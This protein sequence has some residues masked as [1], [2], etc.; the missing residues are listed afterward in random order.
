MIKVWDYNQ[1]Y[2]ILRKKILRC[3]DDVFKSGTLVFGPALDKF[4]KNFTQFIGTKY[5]LGVG[6]GTDALEIAL[7]ACGVGPGDEV[8]TTSNTAV[9]TVTA[10]VNAGA[11]PCFVDVDEFYLMNSNLLENKINNKTK[12]IIPVHL[13]GQSCNMKNINKIAKKNNLYVIEDCAQSHGATYNNKTTGSLGDIGCFSFY[14][15]KILG[16]YGD[17]GFIT[18]NNQKLFDKMMRIRFLGMERKKMSSGHWNGKYYAVEHGTN[19]RLDEVHAA[20]LSVKL[21]YLKSWIK[22]RRNIA[23]KYYKSLNNIGL[24]LP[25]EVKGNE[26]A[27]Y[28]Y[29]VAHEKRDLIIKEFLKNDIHLNISYP[30]PIHIMEPYKDNVC[31]SCYCLENTNAFSKTIFSLPMHPYLQT[32]EQNKVIKVMKKVLSDLV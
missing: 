32:K 25:D 3:I 10:I 4:E 27:Y 24:K 29:V 23:K 15:T 9:P 12:A 28:V 22:K 21:K 31:A 6:N 30:W 14:P 13:Y 26:H 20:I 17:G 8:I 7:K 2:K 19:S 16:G 11:K 1:E 18:T 5:G